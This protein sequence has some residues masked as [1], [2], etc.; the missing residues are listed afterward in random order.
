M[1]VFSAKNVSVA[2]RGGSRALRG[3]DLDFE[4]DCLAVV[5]GEKDGKT[6]LINAIAGLV[7]YSGE[8]VLDGVSLSKKP[9]GA[10]VQAI[11]EDYCILKR[12]T[13]R[14][15]VCYPLYV[16]GA[17][18][19]PAEKAIDEFGLRKYADMR[20]KNVKDN[21]KPYIAVA[22]LGLVKRDLYLFDDVLRAL[23]KDEKSGFLS[24]LKEISLNLE[25][26]KI[27][28]TSDIDEA[29]AMGDKIVV[30]YGG[31]IE[32]YGTYEELL[33]KPLSNKVAEIMS[34][35]NAVFRPTVLRE[36]QGRLIVR[37]DDETVTLEEGSANRLI[38]KR[39]IG[40][41]VQVAK[42]AAGKT[43]KYL[44]T[45]SETDKSILRL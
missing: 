13:V 43:V 28:A 2:Y 4:G 20:A 32:Q 33:E 16:R 44:L 24:K 37:C 11:L 15:N 42:Y 36:Y 22:R 40:R 29:Q 14:E 27:F 23:N 31:V 10:R 3:F 18:T 41:E 6:T 5:G 38:D 45:D 19:A 25:G 35:G 30:L 26:M 17:D 7:G 39:Y 1:H 9:Q 21:V 12:K 34:R 8:F